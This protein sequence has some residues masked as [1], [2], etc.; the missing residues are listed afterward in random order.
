MKPLL[1]TSGT[2]V[3]AA[4]RG[5]A[6]T[7]D[8][9]RA[10]RSGL[11]PCDFAG[12][13]VGF[14]GV[15][16]GVQ[17]HRIGGSDPRFDCRNNRLADMA[18]TTDGFDEAVAQARAFY[19]PER[20]AVVL[21]TSTSGILSAEDAYAR[22]DPATGALPPSFD[23]A[24]THD[25]F[26]LP[27]FV[28]ARLALDGP[29]LSVSNA[30]ASSSRAF[31]DARHWLETGLCDAVVVGGADSLCRMTLRGFDSLGLVAP[32]RARPCDAGRR[33]I[34]V[35]EGAGFMLLEREGARP[36]ART[37]ARWLGYGVSSD[38]H[39]MSTPDPEARGAIRAMLEALR[40]AGLDPSEI[41]YVNLHGTG[42]IANDAMEDLAVHAVF[43]DAVPCASTKG[44]TGHTLGASGIVEALFS[45]LMMRDGF[46]AGCL[47][48]EIVD[49]MFRSHVLT[50]NRAAT[51]RA[52]MSNAFGFGG[53]NCSLVFGAA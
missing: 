26:S 10:R 19:G 17:A 27:R 35:G 48:V 41:D 24:R 37:M 28:A 50:G 20:I 39:H 21:G 33:G 36:G 3:S 29:L 40:H 13:A 6:E 23:Q 47:G 44:W 8:A 49:P 1:I 46:L 11:A 42:T 31:V 53:T 15:V 25:L 4:G 5:L 18:L 45:V 2:V 52:I 30:C 14:A 7:A 12:I 9:L 43:G 38:G 34:S 16:R 51:P 22:A 32:D